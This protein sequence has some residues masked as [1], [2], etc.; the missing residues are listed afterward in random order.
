MKLQGFWGHF[1]QSW[2]PV[3]NATFNLLCC[4]SEAVRH[5]V[6]THTHNLCQELG[7]RQP[8]PE[9]YYTFGTFNSEIHGLRR[10]VDGEGSTSTRWDGWPGEF[11]HMHGCNTFKLVAIHQCKNAGNS[12]SAQTHTCFVSGIRSAVTM[13]GH[14]QYILE[15]WNNEG[16]WAAIVS[17]RRGSLDT[18][19]RWPSTVIHMHGCNRFKMLPMQQSKNAGI[20]HVIVAAVA[21]NKMMMKTGGRGLGC[22]GCTNLPHGQ[23]GEEPGD[24]R[25]WT[26]HRKAVTPPHKDMMD[27]SKRRG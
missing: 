23:E 9:I 18:L 13:S 5:S 7:Q 17:E 12:A 25:G 19:T 22:S 24:Q 26:C 4:Y 14:L 1:Y 8:C 27:S 11:I 10:W 16:A 2:R 21:N 3:P 6:H 15:L 20:G